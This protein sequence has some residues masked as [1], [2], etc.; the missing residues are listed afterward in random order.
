MPRFTRLINGSQICRLIWTDLNPIPAD[1]SQENESSSNHFSMADSSGG[2]SGKGL[3][4]HVIFDM[5]GLLLGN[6]I[7]RLPTAL[8]SFLFHSTPP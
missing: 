4:T 8:P 7:K 2:V 6:F 5:D 1:L 3:I